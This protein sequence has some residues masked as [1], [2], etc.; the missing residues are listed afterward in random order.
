MTLRSVATA[1]GRYVSING[2]PSVAGAR[3]LVPAMGTS[4]RTT[5]DQLSASS[6]T[7]V[8]TRRMKNFTDTLPILIKLPENIRSRIASSLSHSFQETP[9]LMWTGE[10]NRN[11]YGRISWKGKRPVAHRLVYELLVAQIEDGLLLDHK[12]YFRGCVN[13][14]HMEPV[15]H[16]ENTR[17]GRAVLFPRKQG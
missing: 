6:T 7:P 4:S 9:C 2:Q 11:G 14:L 1:A 8:G 13:P 17:R 10:M 16:A 12:C 3:A 15:T 5:V